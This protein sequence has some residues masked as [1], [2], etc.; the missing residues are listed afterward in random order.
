MVF[1]HGFAAAGVL[2]FNLYQYL[3]NDFVFISI[4]LVGMGQSSRPDNFAKHDFTPQQSIDY[5]LEYIE[6]WRLKMGLDKFLMA[7]HS[8]GGYISGHY[9]LRYP[10]HVEK[11]LLISPIG[12][13]VKDPNENDWARFKQ[14][15]VEVKKAGG[16]PPNLVT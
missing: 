2:Y 8:F 12:I 4:D 1:V 3:I 10:Q 6:Q 5:F 16:S 13:R 7:A 11:L 9:A 14:V 15:S